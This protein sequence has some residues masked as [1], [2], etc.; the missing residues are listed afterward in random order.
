MYLSA[1]GNLLDDPGVGDK[2]TNAII[3]HVLG[4]GISWV[5]HLNLQFTTVVDIAEIFFPLVG[6]L[7]QQLGPRSTGGDAWFHQST[8]DGE[9][10]VAHWVIFTGRWGNVDRAGRG[11]DLGGDALLAGA[12]VGVA[13]RHANGVV[14][15][16]E[17]E[18]VADLGGRAIEPQEGT[19]FLGQDRAADVGGN[20][21]IVTGIRAQGHG[22]DPGAALV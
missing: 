4:V 14:F 16:V 9:T 12:V 7:L 21:W 3:S 17:I 5:D 8:R 19:L 20:H 1:G 22:V 18:F 2:E 6:G 10:S 11:C 13:H 15:L